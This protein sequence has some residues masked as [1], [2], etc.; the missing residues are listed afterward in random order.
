MRLHSYVVEHDMGFAPN[1]FHGICT[2]ATCKPKIRRYAKLHEYVIGTGTKK[3]GLQGRL[4]FVMEV[5]EATN[6][7][8]YWNDRR[9][10]RKRPVMNGSF[11]QR[12]GDNIYH[13]DVQTKNWIQKDSFHSQKD[14]VPDTDNM[15]LDTGTTDRVLVGEWFVYWGG[16]GPLIPKH[17]EEF[18]HRGIGHRCIKDN[19][20]IEEFLGWVDSQGEPG[21]RGDPCEW[22][23]ARKEGR[24]VRKVFPANVAA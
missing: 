15:Q 14:G 23:Y 21:V 18:I 22:R 2:L 5:S 17:F 1:P 3:R 19:T 12:Y 13:R 11:V 7:D 4:V 6:F 20:K 8:D 24:L 9:F 16:D 10:I